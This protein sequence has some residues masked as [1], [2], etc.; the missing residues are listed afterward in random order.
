M[1]FIHSQTIVLKC[2]IVKLFGTLSMSK[3]VDPIPSRSQRKSILLSLSS[4]I[5]NT[6]KPVYN[7]QPRDPK[8]GAVV[9]RWSLFRGGFYLKKLKLKLQ[10]S[11]C[12]RQ[13]IV[14]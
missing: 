6:V 9:D 10:N 14:N 12:C 1:P 8:F 4:I 2:K 3:K 13:V 11:G 5:A 7:D